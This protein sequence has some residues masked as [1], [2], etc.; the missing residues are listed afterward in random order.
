MHDHND[1][2]PHIHSHACGD[3]ELTGIW[4]WAVL[5]IAVLAIPSS[6]FLISIMLPAHGNATLPVFVLACWV[7]TYIGMLLMRGSPN[8]K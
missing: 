8:K 3:C 2:E 1:T 5:V 7:S 4:W 6:G